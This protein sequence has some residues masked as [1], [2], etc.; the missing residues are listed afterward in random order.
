M[1][2]PDPIDWPEYCCAILRNG[3]GRLLLEKRAA[4]ARHAPGLLACFGGKRE[5]GEHPDRCLRRELQ[6]ELGWSIG[7]LHVRVAVRLRERGTERSIAWFYLGRPPR[8]DLPLRTLPGSQIVWVGP[9]EIE[10]APLSPW[11]RAALLAESRGEPVA[12][13][14]P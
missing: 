9:R 4:T 8:P 12:W 6:E 7:A 1:P 3:E 10:S 5:P 14:E 13:I 11:H 2:P